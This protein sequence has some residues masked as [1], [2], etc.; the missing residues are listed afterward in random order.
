MSADPQAGQQ[1]A[2][3]AAREEELSAMTSTD[4]MLQATVLLINIGGRRLGL[5]PPSPSPEELAAARADRDLEQV[6]DCVDAVRA[7]LE[8]LERTLTAAELRPLRDALSQLQMAYAREVQSAAADAPREPAQP[9]SGPE[10]AA[11]REPAQP[12]Q[13]ASG[14]EPAATGAPGQ[15]ASAPESEAAGAPAQ[16]TDTPSSPEQGQ[17]RPGP[18]E[19]SGRLWVPGR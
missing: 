19:E 3:Q 11:P 13:P 15:A 14:P 10:P 8:V 5:A 2:D 9:A 6:R 1:A 7:L 17:R 12:A 4:M 18:A 16:A